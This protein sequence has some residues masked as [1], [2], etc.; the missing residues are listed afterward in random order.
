MELFRNQDSTIQSSEHL[1][2]VSHLIP[3]TISGEILN[4]Q[5]QIEKL[6]LKWLIKSAQVPRNPLFFSLLS[7]ASWMRNAAV[8]MAACTLLQTVRK[9]WS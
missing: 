7:T 5:L 2:T 1:H 9:H 8:Q 3:Q 4:Y 6:R